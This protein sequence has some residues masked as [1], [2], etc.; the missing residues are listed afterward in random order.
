MVM[1]KE[2]IENLKQSKAIGYLQPVL[3]NNKT[4]KVLVGRHRKMADPNWPEIG[5]DVA[6]DLTEELIILNGNVQRT[7]TREE[8]RER[9]LR[10]A[11]ILESKG[12]PKDHVAIEMGKLPGMYSQS[13]ISILLK[14]FPEYKMVSLTRPHIEAQPPDKS[15]LLV[16]PK[17]DDDIVRT[18]LDSTN[19]GPLETHY[20]FPDCRCRGCGNRD[21]CPNI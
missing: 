19:E 10:I 16:M 1:D 20:P 9:L 18:A 4:G 2:A 7:P 14:D 13:W 6:D 21:K 15:A 8:T 11:K 17:P 5:L 12:I 3:V